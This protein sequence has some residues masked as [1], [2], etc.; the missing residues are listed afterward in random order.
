MRVWEYESI[1]A[2]ELSMGVW[3]YGSMGVDLFSIVWSVKFIVQPPVS[4][5]MGADAPTLRFASRLVT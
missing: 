2:W 5:D 3:A 4:D 1:G